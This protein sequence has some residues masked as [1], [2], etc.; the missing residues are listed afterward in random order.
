MRSFIVH[1]DSLVMAHGLAHGLHF[2]AAYGIWLP[3]PEIEPMSPALQ[4]EAS[5]YDF[6]NM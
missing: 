5:T 3:W 1:M 6:Y 4:D 2:P